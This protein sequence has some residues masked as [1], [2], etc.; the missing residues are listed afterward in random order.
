VG[1]LDCTPGSAL[2]P[3][4]FNKYGKPLPFSI[5]SE[6]WSC[7]RVGVEV[8][9]PNAYKSGQGGGRKNYIFL[10]TYLMDGPRL[11]KPGSS[12]EWL[13]LCAYL[14]QHI[15]TMR[16]TSKL[17][18]F[19]WCILKQ[20]FCKSV[21]R[22]VAGD[23][24]GALLRGVKREFVERGMF[25][26]VPGQLK[27]SDHIA[28]RLYILTKAEGGRSKPITSGFADM[29][30]V[31]TWTMAARIEFNDRPMTMPGDLVDRAELILRKPMVVREGLRFVIRERGSTV[32]SGVITE[33][34]PDSGLEIHGFNYIPSKRMVIESNTAVVRRKKAA[35]PTKPLSA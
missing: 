2:G 1:R 25:L 35:R 12:K 15:V 8:R 4:L 6:L 10:Q 23:N 13:C 33:V 18:Y 34:L 26:G 29:A 5:G 22:A 11:A 14:I 31:A 16:C 30:H 27:Q 28:A 20:V 17:T 24:M 21:P 32:I 3:M 7:R 9:T 19:S